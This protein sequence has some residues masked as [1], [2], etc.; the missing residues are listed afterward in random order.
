MAVAVAVADAR[1]HAVRFASLRFGFHLM[2]VVMMMMM[3]MMMM[4]VVTVRY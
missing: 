1:F 2:M 4:R 3:M